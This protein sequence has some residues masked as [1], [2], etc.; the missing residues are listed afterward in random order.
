VFS[1]KYYPIVEYPPEL[2]KSDFWENFWKILETDLT[3]FPFF[4][5]F[6]R[7]NFS[8][9]IDPPVQNPKNPLYK[10]GYGRGEG[11]G[12]PPI[13]LYGRE[14]VRINSY[15]CHCALQRQQIITY[16]AACAAVLILFANKVII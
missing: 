3:P 8:R 14:G 13:P 11:Q 12:G 1:Y 6:F 2:E 10:G 15:Q 9:G 7:K 16:G 5:D 4:R